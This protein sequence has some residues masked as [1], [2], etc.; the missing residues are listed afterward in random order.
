MT[1]LEIYISIASKKINM[2]YELQTLVNLQ[3]WVYFDWFGVTKD[4]H[5]LI[6]IHHFIKNIGLYCDVCHDFIILM[7]YEYFN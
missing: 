2:I 3:H 4:D 6:T 5:S 7:T 1:C